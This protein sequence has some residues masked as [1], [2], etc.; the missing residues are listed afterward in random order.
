MKVIEVSSKYKVLRTVLFF[1]AA[2]VAVT[3]ISLGVLSIGHKDPGWQEISASADSQAPL[4]SSEY[5]FQYYAEGSSNQ[6]KGVVRQVTDTYSRTLARAYKLTDPVNTYDGYMNLAVINN[7][8]G[9]DVQLEQELFDILCS[10][11]ELT[12][13]NEGYNM[14]SGPL[15]SE[16]HSILGS[17]NAQSFDPLFNDYQ[18]QR[19]AKLAEAVSDSSNYSFEIVDRA[20]RIV[21]FSVS[22]KFKNLLKEL[23]LDVPV[24]DLN[25]LRDAY[26]MDTVRKDLVSQN[27]NAGQMFSKSGSAFSL[28]SGQSS[29]FVSALPVSGYNYYFYAV[30]KDGV[31]YFRNPYFDTRTGNFHNYVLQTTVKGSDSDIVEVAY[32][33]YMIAN[34]DNVQQV[35][36]MS[37]DFETDV[38]TL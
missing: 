27:L 1:V 34:C 37:S 33:A 20:E 29:A 14:F 6:I 22:E 12:K 23:E 15:Y 31:E 5:T 8:T 16:W 35:R 36:A 2:G 10:A 19:I 21:R 32:T 7:S 3:A 24:L 25:V 18:A 4:Y 26:I 17:D 13:R 30:Q 9:S 38:I 28:V 11:Y